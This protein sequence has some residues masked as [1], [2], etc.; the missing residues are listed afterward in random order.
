[1]DGPRARLS[2]MNL[3]WH[4]RAFAELT[5]AELHAIEARRDELVAP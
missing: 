1:M 4:D 3:R 5:T 2:A